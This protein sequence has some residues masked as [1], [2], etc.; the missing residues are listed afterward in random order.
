METATQRKKEGMK[1]ITK[2]SLTQTNK[3]SFAARWGS[4]IVCFALLLLGTTIFA[5]AP[6]N[7][8]FANAT[9]IPSA[10]PQT[11]TG[12]TTDATAETGEPFHSD[13]PNT[14]QIGRNTIWWVW[15]A[16]ASGSVT[17]DTENSGTG[18][19]TELGV[20][21]GTSV[22]ALTQVAV[23]E[24]SPALAH[25]WSRVT[26]SAVGGTTYHIAVSGF[27]NSSGP[28]TLNLSSGGTVIT[29]FTLTVNTT[30]SGTVTQSPAQPASGYASNDVVTVV[31]HPT[32]TNTFL[33]WTGT[34]ESDTNLT[35]TVTMSSSKTI[36]AA[37]TGSTP[38]T[39][40]FTL[41]VIKT[42]TSS[43]GTVT[44]IPN[45]SRYNDGE[46]VTVVARPAKSRTFV[47]WSGTDESSGDTTNHVT[48]TSDKTITAAF[49]TIEPGAF[50]A[51]VGTYNGLFFNT[52]VTTNCSG[53]FT[54]KVGKTGK[55]T[56]KLKR[57]GKTF[58]GSGQLTTNGV[59]TATIGRAPG[60]I[61]TV[62]VQIDIT[63]A[64]PAITGTITTPDCTSPLEGDRVV[65]S[66]KNPSPIQGI[67]TFIL[68][69]S[70][71]SG[72][73]TNDVVTTNTVVVTN[74]PGTTNEMVVTNT[75]F[76]TN[77]VVSTNEVVLNAGHS[78][79]L[80]TITKSGAAK[81]RC[82]LADG[83]KF[84]QST[85]ISTNGEIPLFASLYRGHGLLIG[86]LH[87]TATEVTG[88]PINWK[89]PAGGLFPN[90]FDADITVFGSKFDRTMNPFIDLGTNAVV[91]IGA[92]N[93]D[94]ASQI[95]PVEFSNANT[96][97]EAGTN[98]TNGLL[99]KLL[100]TGL[101]KGKFIS[102]IT[103]KNT[104]LQG[105]MVQ[106]TNAA[107]GFFLSTGTSGFFEL[108]NEP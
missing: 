14:A 63:G 9:L 1:K 30:G 26:F 7:D 44:K 100:P 49:S 97:V 108:R 39:N 10:L 24:D 3:R 68:P 94:T 62:D 31:A 15:T 106:N 51:V 82:A 17:I 78:Y 67:Y 98:T 40:T 19:D 72:S 13:W 12:N 53:Y 101:V 90:D 18:V 57:A 73:Q 41:T 105:A 35:N 54:V 92:N 28:I 5:V 25:G 75:T 56:V 43:S 6:V 69:R 33:G 55:F 50:D 42:P 21:T 77:T 60:V 8:N 66:S 80:L 88:S 34:T 74:F 95:I 38:G 36:T 22:G 58:V 107:F 47:G 81:I 16:P 96:V 59:G 64:D 102:P 84:N 65:F 70:V 93:S 27:E 83:T 103:G 37:F 48:M 4:A 71:T 79:A 91:E 52:E 32:G 2:L 104:I 29:G 85:T 23:N 46:V 87:V 11:V 99:I 20:Y 61:T 45:K 89:R 86:W 76:Q